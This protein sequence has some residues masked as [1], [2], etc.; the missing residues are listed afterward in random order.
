MRKRIINYLIRK[1]VKYHTSAI[2]IVVLLLIF[3]AFFFLYQYF[4]R[5]MNDIAEIYQ[6][7]GEVNFNIINEELLDEVYGGIEEKVGR[8]NVSLDNISSPF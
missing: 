1:A 4:L 2:L 7:K 6:L 3:V 5:S 8:E